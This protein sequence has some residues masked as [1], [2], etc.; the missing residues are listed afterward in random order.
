MPQPRKFDHDEARRRYTAGEK[1]SAL[2][3]EFGVTSNAVLRIASP[4]AGEAFKRASAAFYARNHVP[5]EVC[6]KSCLGLTITSKAKRCPDG[7]ALCIRCRADERRERLLFDEQGNLVSVRCLALDCANGERWQSP[8]NFANGQR[9]REVRAGGIH[10]R[11]RACGTRDRREYRH[12]NPAARERE[13]VA[14]MAR[15]YRRK[16]TA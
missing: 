13:N 9:H 6:G 15:Y 8:D 3:A 12:R 16:Q 5:C 1:A 10:N 2:A 7:R 11:C 14:R 4:G